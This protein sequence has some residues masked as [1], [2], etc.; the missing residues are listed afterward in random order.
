MNWMNRAFL[1]GTAT[2]HDLDQTNRPTPHPGPLPV[3]GRGEPDDA[4]CF[5]AIH[6]PVQAYASAGAR[7]ISLELKDALT[8]PPSPLNGERAGVRGEN[9]TACLKHFSVNSLPAA[10]ET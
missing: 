2:V 3:E 6:C 1:I 4:P 10:P 5:S 9:N 8:V 7:R